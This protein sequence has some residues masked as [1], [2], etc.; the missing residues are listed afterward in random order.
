MTPSFLTFYVLAFPAIVAVV[1]FV[2]VR[3]FWG[4]WRKARR[5]GRSII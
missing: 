1:L 5:Q 2:L 4:E 3:A